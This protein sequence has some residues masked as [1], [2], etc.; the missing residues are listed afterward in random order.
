MSRTGSTPLDPPL[1]L[2]FRLGPYELTGLLG[3][4]GMGEVYRARDT[5]LNRTVAVKL[6]PRELSDS[7]PA[8]QRFEREARAIASLNHPKVCIVHDVSHDG[9]R[10]YI[11]ME[12]LEGESLAARLQRGPLPLNDV[13]QYGIEIAE[14]LE[15]A[16]AMGIVHR[17]VKPGNVIITKTGAKIVDFGLAALRP[18]IFDEETVGD[19]ITRPG[20]IMGTLQYMAPEQLEGKESDARTDLFACGLVLYEMVTAKR[21]FDGTSSAAIISAILAH[22]APSIRA[23]EP[24]YSSDLDW[25]IRRCLAKQPTHRWQTAADLAAVLRWIHGKSDVAA[26]AGGD[27]APARAHRGWRTPAVAAATALVLVLGTWFLASRASRGGAP[28]STIPIRTAITVVPDARVGQEGTPA[29]ALSRDGSRLAYTAVVKGTTGLFL[30]HLDRLDATLLPGTEGAATPFFSP[31]GASIAFFAGGKLKRVALD[32]S[33][34]LVVADAPRGRG[35]SWMT[36]DTIIF[37]PSSDTA[38][39]RVDASGGD[40]DPVSTLHG[41]PPERS[42]RWPDVLPGGRAVLFTSGNPTDYLFSDAQIIAQSLDGAR[43]RRV[44]VQGGAYGRYADGHLFF[45]RGRSVFAVPFDPERLQVTGNPVPVV[46][47]PSKSHYLGSA[48]YA[49]SSQGLLAYLPAGGGGAELTWIARDG[50][51]TPV[52]ALLG[53]FGAPRLSPD[54]SR[55]AFNI[56]DAQGDIGVYEFGTSALSRVTHYPEFEGNPIWSPD[57]SRVL[58]ASDRGAGMQM[59]WKRWNDPRGSPG[60]LAQSTTPDETLAPGVFPRLPQAWSPDGR[61]VAFTEN[62]PDTRRDIW[63]A[64]FPGESGKPYPLVATPFEDNHA[65]FSPDGKWIAYQSNDAG[66]D[67]IYVQPF[68]AAGERVAVSPVDSYSP[69]WA[70][71]ELF[72]WRGGRIF[73]VALSTEGPTLR[74]GATKSVFEMPARL[75]YDVSPD[76]RRV[77]VPQPRA[78]APATHLVLVQH[79]GAAAR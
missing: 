8:R 46:Q 3:R 78:S 55:V 7:T 51:A 40:L 24:T 50:S 38:L 32:G 25:T 67:V 9:E 6:L 37:A 29:I 2:P 49:V 13:L 44:L 58:F 77:I 63:I 48:Q 54:G 74:V 79:W 70:N 73:A 22:P 45:V 42:H 27:T 68:P 31:D 35:G 52:G 65:V 62:H 14:G 36:R 66:G 11:V 47:E 10:P 33:M 20:Q 71:G 18:T 1:P 39:F 75:S 60:A 16:H 72:Y 5:R 41:D 69:R 12:Y 23:V 26:A 59:M 21:A 56:E 30:R 34:P 17:D 61:F 28:A 76:G 15:H 19:A 4:G 43:E 53:P 57:G 64:P